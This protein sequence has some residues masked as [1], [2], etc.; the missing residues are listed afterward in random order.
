MN[1]RGQLEQ[2]AKIGY[3]IGVLIFAIV[4]S[5]II[6][7]SGDPYHLAPLI[8]VA[9]ALLLVYIGIKS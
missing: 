3:F 5:A 8:G 4:I 6:D 7:A 1:E 9:L 2:L